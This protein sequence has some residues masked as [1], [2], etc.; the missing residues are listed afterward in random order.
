MGRLVQDVRYGLRNLTRNPGFALVAMLTLALGIG[1]NTTVFSVINNTL[2][3]PLAFPGADRLVLVWETFGKGPDNWNIVSAPNFW[4]FER[5]SHSFER[6]AIFDSA[7]RGYNLSAAGARQEAKQVS[8][9]RV[10]AGFFSV[11][12]VKPFIGRTFLPE[13]ETTGR[14]HEVVLSYGLWKRRYGGD[15]S[16]VGRTIRID[17]ADFT[18][19]GVM[20]HDF[21][22]QFWSAP[23][24]LWVPVGYTKTD[25]GRGDNSF[26][27]IGR[28]KPG[29]SVAQARA[30]MEAVGSN[31]QRQNP[32]E[33][34]DMGATVSP[35]GD[36]GME[37]L[38]TTMLAL[39]AAVAFILLIACV[40]VANLLLAR[41]AA[42]QKEFA[43]RRALGAAGSRIMAQLLTESIILA[44]A[45][46]VA[47]LVLAAWSNRILFYAFKLDSL[48]L[49]LRAV[50]SI[51]MDGRVFGFALVVSA[52]T[53]VLFG[54][55]PA[56]SALRTG[57]NEPLKEGGRSGATGGRNRLRHVLVA[58]EVALAMVVLSGAGL[59]IKSMT[60]LLSVDPGLNPKNVLILGM[61]V[62]QEEIYVGPPGLPRFCQDLDEHVGAIPGVVS[63]GAVAHLP[64]EGNAGRSF[65]IE[66]RPP[67][68]PGQ[69]PGAN[70]TVACPNYFRTMGIPIVRGRE[71]TTQDTVNAPGVIV[72]NETM[73][74]AFWPKED[75][76]G[77]AIRL[78]GSDGPRLTIVGVAGDV[79][80]VGLD[81]PVQRQFFR[82]YMQAG[83]PVMT[84]VV[85]T[86]HAPATFAAPVKKALAS[87][88]PDWPVAGFQTMEEVVH[89]STGSRRFPMLLLSVFSV[90]ALGLAAVGIVGVVGHSVTQR[91]HEIGLRMAL[92]A[93]TMDVL[94]LVVS[95]NMVW[96]LV[97]LAAGLAGSAALTRLL[98]GLLYGVRPLDPVVLGGVSVLLAAVALFASYLPA[99]RAAKIDP[100]AALRIE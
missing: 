72:I 47:G 91:T 37:G 29:V 100:M 6:M 85:R 68:A 35:L 94:R 99:R 32:K 22:W 74:R 5:Q 51:P 31:V 66:G 93:R 3:K 46:G 10:T 75:P 56:L 95:S 57:I 53:G 97:G 52:L 34:A 80:H 33:D 96:V 63:V 88:L 87:A 43:I 17:S 2:L 25:Y 82:P 15:P 9:L 26:I 77:R 69:F 73:A 11:L 7:G 70:Y 62:P 76:I 65:Q 81:A 14:D 84:V 19:I 44:L 39:L 8:G 64:F 16:L 60:R 20:P 13:E 89:D 50:D 42:R 27:A 1:A 90:V 40:N 23:R 30:E 71:F 4:D 24:Q 92:G 28:L 55:A 54:V 18:V 36:Y 38:R 98:A 61:S 48:Y 67:A 58:S 78:G 49:P 41:G 21:S 59:M 83:W 12:G 79:H 45:G 86:I